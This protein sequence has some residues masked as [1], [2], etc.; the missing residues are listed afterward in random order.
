[1]TGGTVAVAA[2]EVLG[3]LLVAAAAAFGL[4]DLFGAWAGLLA[5]GA[6]VLAAAARAQQMLEGG[7]GAAVRPSAP[8]VDR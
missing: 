7:R 4:G 2:L 3:V 5:A 1:M 6:I 8:R